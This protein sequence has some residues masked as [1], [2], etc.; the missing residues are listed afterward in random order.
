MTKMGKYMNNQTKMALIVRVLLVLV[1]YHLSLLTSFSQGIPFLKNYMATDYH[2]HSSNFDVEIGEDGFVYFANFE[3]LMYYDRA[4]WHIIHTPGITRVTVVYCDKNDVVWAGGY[5]YFGRIQRKANGELYLQQVGDA[6]LFRGEVLEIYENKSGEL[7]FVVNDGNVYQVDGEKVSI[8][9]K[10]SDGALSIGL[11]DVIKVDGLENENEIVVLDDVTQTEPLGNGLN[12]VVKKGRGLAIT[13]E[14]GHELYTVTEANGL[15]ANNVIYVAYDGHGQLWGATDNGIFS[16]AIPSAY[17]HFTRNEG[18][19]GEA[20]SI[21]IFEGRKYIGT[22]HGLFRQDGRN[23]SKVKG[24]DYACWDLTATKQG[25]L[26]ATVNG[27]YRIFADGNTRQLTNTSSMTLMDEGSQ[28]YSGEMD[29]LYLIQTADNSRKKLCNLEKI[30]KIMKDAEGTIWIQNMY[31]E[32]WYK[33]STAKEFT[34]YHKGQSEETAA[35]I[36]PLAGKVEIINA[37]ATKPFPYPLFSFLDENGTTW[38]TDNKSKQLYR[39]KDGKRIDDRLSQMMYPFENLAIRAM[40]TEKDVIWLGSDDGFTVIDTSVDDPAL[41]TE[42]QLLIRSVILGSD[43]ILWSGYGKAPSSL[44]TLGSNDRNLRFTYSL[45]YAPMVG[46][47]LYRYQLNDGGWS[48][49]A[50]DIDAEFINLPHGSYI[51]KVQARDAYGRETD[52]TTINFSIAYPVYLRWYMLILY[53]ILAGL[54]LYLIV[55]LRLRKLER[56]KMQLEKVVQERTAEVVK[57]KDEIEEKS[58]SLEKALDDLNT[59]Q[60]ELIRQEKMAT[61][62]KLTQGLIDRILNPLNYINNFTKLSEGLVKDVEDN[63]DDDKD[64]MDEDNYEDTK[65]VLD[66][67]RGNLL[68]VG[69]HG[70]NTTRT[71]KA[72]EEMLKDRSGG[73]IKMDLA[74]ILKQDVEMV[75]TY[76][77]NDVNEHHIKVTLDMPE[78][79]LPINGNAEQLSKTLMSLLGNSI[80][81]IV[82]KAQREKYQPEV[83]LTVKT[84]DDQIQLIVYDNG[85]GIE[86]TII[87]K[88]FDP[89]FTTKP[90]GEASGVGLYLSREIIQNHGGDIHVTSVKNEYSEFTITLPAITV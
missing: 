47:T 25:L 20:M 37:E 80:Y 49:W 12:V 16:M 63:I 10:M 64:N 71:L 18:L 30:S 87:N 8:K 78:G 65:E 15:C 53:L 75:Q 14:A 17:S 79:E 69:E 32:V 48:A 68:K 21:E 31:G 23:F 42:P 76:Y 28:F 7:N 1:T 29:G 13:D 56:D 59:A 43:S 2:A 54:L 27:I 57:Q 52:I 82:K 44:P 88:I 85:I 46:T 50:E 90:T 84:A 70:Q 45:D 22:N 11:S 61:V 6:G 72:M 40:L 19:T 55:Q 24:V 41:K 62:G 67:L 74:R 86:D 83:K 26:A 58:K 4:E 77:A 39:W 33:S 51:F 66:M 5:N 73:I 35:T 81:A 9:A 3:G 60:N 89:F 36:V 34:S 38:L